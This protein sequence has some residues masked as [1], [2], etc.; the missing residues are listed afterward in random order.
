VR[1]LDCTLFIFAFLYIYIYII[2]L[3]VIEEIGASSGLGYS[4]LNSPIT[5]NESEVCDE[6]IHGLLSSRT[7][8]LSH[9]LVRIQ[10]SFIA[11]IVQ[12]MSDNAVETPQNSLSGKFIITLFPYNLTWF[13]TRVPSLHVEQKTLSFP[14]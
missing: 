5:R 7:Q 11:E 3:L 10:Q 12:L 6:S 9:Y 13:K 14:G 1:A 8:Q 4:L 2:F